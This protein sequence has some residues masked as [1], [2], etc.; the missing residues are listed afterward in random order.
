MAGLAATAQAQRVVQTAKGSDP[1]VPA[2]VATFL[3]LPTCSSGTP[4]V[5][6][7]PALP[8]SVH[9][10]VTG[11]R[12][13]LAGVFPASPASYKIAAAAPANPVNPQR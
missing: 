10:V 1:N 5:T 7:S 12:S 3:G 13:R 11:L 2:G 9:A 4:T 8:A 6:S